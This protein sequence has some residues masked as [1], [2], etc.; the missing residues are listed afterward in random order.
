MQ[1]GSTASVISSFMS[2]R[3]IFKLRRGGR[4]H[5][6]EEADD[7]PACTGDMGVSSMYVGTNMHWQVRASM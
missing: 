3:M 1:H 5:P 6:Y 7:L 4:I 2:A